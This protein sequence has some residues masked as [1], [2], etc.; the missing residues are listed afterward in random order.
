MK[1][2]GDF[3]I[4]SLLIS[5]AAACAGPVQD[6]P[7]IR[8]YTDLRG[9][10]ETVVALA[11]DSQGT[12]LASVGS[13]GQI[14]LWDIQTRKL[15]QKLFPKEKFVTDKSF[16]RETPRRVEAIAFSPDGRRLLEAAQE[17]NGMLIL[18]LWD[19]ASGTEERVLARGVENL[20]AIAYAPDG[21]AIA[22][23][24]RDAVGWQHKIVLRDSVSGDEL[25]SM[26]DTNLSATNLA[27]S[28]DGKTLASAGGKRIHIW[29]VA[30]RR[31]R[32]A[33]DAHEKTIQSIC[34]SPNGKWVVSGAADDKVKVWNVETGKLE[35]EIK[36]GQESVST[37]A[38]SP[39]G[40]TIASAG[41]DR[42]TKLW[43]PKSGKQYA[44]LWG[45]LDR[46]NCLAYNPNDHTLATGSSDSTI[47]L[48]KIKEPEEIEPDEKGKSKQGKDE[49]GED[50]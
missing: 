14:F 29:D 37:V 36:A 16:R 6:A 10:R 11:F 13:E 48:W 46:V 1:T 8:P 50:D 44:R 45:H 23:N 7:D 49:W 24:T 21:N 39:S 4:G 3:I 41:K 47:A 40:K 31:L 20:R 35:I 9:H 12:M 27:F 5:A 42:T 18:R 30:G 38:F 2:R 28:P 22:Y 26:T 19:V 34:F 43:K 15:I 32:H 25:G 33:I 17:P